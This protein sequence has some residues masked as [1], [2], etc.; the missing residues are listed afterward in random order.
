MQIGRGLRLSPETGKEDCYIID[1][2]DNMSRGLSVSPTLLGLTHDM[3]E[4][5]QRER[6]ERLARESGQLTAFVLSSKLMSEQG[7]ATSTENPDKPKGK[8]KVQFIDDS[9]P[10]GLEAGEPRRKVIAQMTHLAWVS[11][12]GSPDQHLTPGRRGKRSI[13]SRHYQELV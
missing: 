8:Y 13:H 4:E 5:E 9:D 3:L 1:V 6:E 7:E 10:F 12:Q 11:G 2:V